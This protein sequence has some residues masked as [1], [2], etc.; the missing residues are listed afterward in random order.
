MA[1][2]LSLNGQDHESLLA[3]LDT[4]VQQELKTVS[5]KWLSLKF[6]IPVNSCKQL[7]QQYYEQNKNKV[8]V[9]YFVSGWMLDHQ[10]QSKVLAIRVVSSEILENVKNQMQ[11]IMSMH[12]YSVSPTIP[13]DL[14]SIVADD[15][16]LVSE[17]H[18]KMKLG[19]S[20]PGE[21]PLEKSM[22]S[23]IINTQISRK[24]IQQFAPQQ[25]KGTGQKKIVEKVT[26]KNSAQ[27]Q[28]NKS[29][30]KQE[31]QNESLTKKSTPKIFQKASKKSSRK[32]TNVNLSAQKQQESESKKQVLQ[33]EKEEAEEERDILDSDY[34]QE[35]EEITTKHS[36][37]IIESDQEEDEAMKD[38]QQT[39]E[40]IQAQNNGKRDVRNAFGNVVN[41]NGNSRGKKR[42]VLKTVFNEK[43]EEV[44]QT[45][46]EDV[47]ETE[48]QKEQKQQQQ[49]IQQSV[50]SKSP[51]SGIV[52]AQRKQQQ[53]ST[54]LGTK[55]STKTQ[56]QK[57]SNITSFFKK[58]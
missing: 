15:W 8:E 30:Q 35:V 3:V 9:M 39:K 10:N 45:V 20:E 21:N 16:Q 38:N 22:G 48:E 12:V 7:L 34:E 24:Q 19:E 49:Q 28:D 54:A 1:D 25:T 57:Q 4:R 51:A 31:Q 18:S 56:K 17:L 23:Q 2:S 11:Q 42:K 32:E 29:E 27:L 44:T 26:N 43:G 36:A 33:V 41:N 58:Q 5:Y 53:Q 50:V 37:M 52:N 6:D 47:P 14:N 13:Q 55:R 46:Y 40:H